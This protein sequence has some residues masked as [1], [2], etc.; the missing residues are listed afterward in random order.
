MATMGFTAE[1]FAVWEDWVPYSITEAPAM[2]SAVVNTEMTV[3]VGPIRLMP[4]IEFVGVEAGATLWM[5]NNMHNPN[6][7]CHSLEWSMDIAYVEVM[8]ATNFWECN[9]SLDRML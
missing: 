5:M 9:V 4:H 3:T 7:M 8:L 1:T 6:H 2:G